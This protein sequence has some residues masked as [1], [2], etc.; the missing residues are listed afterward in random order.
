MSTPITYF[1]EKIPKKGKSMTTD[2]L[3][4]MLY[5]SKDTCLFSH[6]NSLIFPCH[7]T[8]IFNS[9]DLPLR[10]YINGKLIILPEHIRTIKILH[11]RDN[12]KVI[13]DKYNTCLPHFNQSLDYLPPNL[14]FLKIHS[15][16]FCQPLDNLPV[17]LKCLKINCKK[18]TTID[19]GY[20]T[21]LTKLESYTSNFIS[22]PESVIHLKV[23]YVKQICVSKSKIKILE[24]DQC[25]FKKFCFFGIGD[26]KL[27]LIDDFSFIPESVEIIIL[28]SVNGHECLQNL[29]CG[30]QQLHV[31]EKI[32]SD[33]YNFFDNL[34]PV[35]QLLN[36]IFN[37]DL[38]QHAVD[39]LSGRFTI[40]PMC[41]DERTKSLCIKN[42]FDK[43]SELKKKK[44]TI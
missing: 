31:T 40:T 32:F 39:V 33:Y 35:L 20:L 4:N 28:N 12:C 24:I 3:D 19:V 25:K 44:N 13:Y 38:V 10:K 7:D 6:E 18:I 34:P 36:I 9:V 14:E 41:Y 23:K 22:I 5:I 15:D 29:P 37:N 11:L 43:I 2:K 27:E 17:N 30:L 8:L 42:S 21:K 16:E 1:Y 26:S